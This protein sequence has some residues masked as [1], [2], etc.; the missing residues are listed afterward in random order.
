MDVFLV[1][2]VGILLGGVVNA[3]ADALPAGRWLRSPRYAGGETRPVL[4]WLGLTAFLFKKRRAGCASA[5]LKLTWRHPLTELTLAALL[6]ANQFASSDKSRVFAG[7]LLIWHLYTTLFVLIAVVDL[8]HRR[9]YIGPFTLIAA[10]AVVDSIV[11]AESSLSLP[12]AIAGGLTGGLAFLLIYL[13]GRFYCRIRGINSKLTVFGLGDVYLMSVCGLI[14]GFPHVF[15]A[16]MSAI[17]LGGIVAA[18][19]VTVQGSLRQGYQPLASLPYA[20]FVL[21]STY[22]VMVFHNHVTALLYG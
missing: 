1:A 10:L 22:L 18:V 13:G 20:P 8:E 6:V 4:A 14:L 15:L 21:V 3:I 9:I 5:G 16:L 2:I 7:Q 19:C 12:S 17:F 11:F